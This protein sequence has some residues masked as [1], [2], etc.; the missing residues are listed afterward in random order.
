MDRVETRYWF[1]I[2]KNNKFLNCLRLFR[3][4]KLQRFLYRDNNFK[5]IIDNVIE[6]FPD[7]L[8]EFYS[9]SKYFGLYNGFE[10]NKNNLHKIF[11]NSLTNLLF[12]IGSMILH[13]P[14]IKPYTSLL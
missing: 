7:T 10:N 5:D 2:S 13:E 11:K 12:K 6:N 14:P 4:I 1:Y 9:L 3:F 8:V